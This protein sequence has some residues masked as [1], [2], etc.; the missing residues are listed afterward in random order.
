MIGR[1]PGSVDYAQGRIDQI[2]VVE[3]QPPSPI[4]NQDEKKQGKMRRGIPA[5]LDLGA[6]TDA[7]CSEQYVGQNGTYEREHCQQHQS[8]LQ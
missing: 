2:V 1:I 4:G 6:A 8:G 7:Q 3:V 5:C